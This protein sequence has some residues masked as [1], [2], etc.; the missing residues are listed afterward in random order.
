MSKPIDFEV[1]ELLPK[2]LEKLD[3]LVNEVNYLKKELIPKLDLTKRAGVLKFLNISV[4]TLS[5]I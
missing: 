2:L 4:S 1:L 5:Y 3:I